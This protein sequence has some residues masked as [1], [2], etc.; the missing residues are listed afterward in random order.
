MSKRPK[1]RG[2]RY[3]PRVRKCFICGDE[4]SQPEEAPAGVEISG[5]AHRTCVEDLMVE[6]REDCSICQDDDPHQ[7]LSGFWS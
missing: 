6:V 2:G 1:R 3:T 7:H 5:W 4:M